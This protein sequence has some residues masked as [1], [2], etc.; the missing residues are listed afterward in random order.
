M[1]G[2]GCLYFKSGSK[3]LT[4]SNDENR[5]VDGLCQSK[6]SHRPKTT[7]MTIPSPPAFFLLAGLLALVGGC[8]QSSK[9]QGVSP[10]DALSTFALAEGFQI[11]LIAAEPLISYPV[12]MEIDEHGNM[13]VAEMHGYPLDKSGSGMVK[14]LRDADGD[15]VM[16]EAMVFADK[17]K[18]PT[19]VMRWK[20]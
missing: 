14:L 1:F 20:K 2:N 13:Y 9:T 3:T 11:E 4:S 17:L 12:A 10:S 15:G 5:A 6:T 19:G 16:D 8:K 18:F 7:L